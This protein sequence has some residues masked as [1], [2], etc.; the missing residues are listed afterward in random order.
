MMHLGAKH[1]QVACVITVLN[2][3]LRPNLCRL[4]PSALMQCCAMHAD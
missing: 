1:S 3:G 2:C 4:R